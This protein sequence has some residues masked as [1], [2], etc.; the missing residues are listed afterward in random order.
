MAGDSKDYL[1]RQGIEGSWFWPLS[2]NSRFLTR[3][4]VYYNRGL[5]EW[6]GTK[7][8]EHDAEH[9]FGLI[10]YQKAAAEFG[11]GWSK[12]KAHLKMDWVISI[13]IWG[14]IP[15]ALSIA[16]PMEKGMTTLTMASRCFMSIASIRF[17]PN[18][19]SGYMETM[20]MALSTKGFR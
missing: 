13:G 17:H 5:S 8:F 11:V 4:V 19:W 18:C 14:K 2:E 10:G 12:T 20:A 6:E 7:A 1:L 3:G 16:Q 9:Y 15:V